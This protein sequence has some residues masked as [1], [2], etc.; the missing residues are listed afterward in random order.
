MLVKSIWDSPATIAVHLLRLLCVDMGVSWA[1]AGGR[2]PLGSAIPADVGGI[3]YLWKALQTRG[4]TVALAAVAVFV[5]GV[6]DLVVVDCACV[7]VGLLVVG[8][9]GA[10]GGNADLVGGGSG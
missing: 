1:T 3:K 10:V 8:G 9:G 2:T 6:V 7:V 4:V 5:D